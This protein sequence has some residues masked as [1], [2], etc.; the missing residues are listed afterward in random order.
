MTD[1]LI[2]RLD[3][4]AESDDTPTV[5]YLRRL[6]RVAADA[7][8]DEAA[9]ITDLAG[10]V[11]RLLVQLD[12]RDAA[13]VWLLWERAAWQGDNLHGIY[14]SQQTAETARTNLAKRGVRRSYDFFIEEQP[15]HDTP[16]TNPQP[17]WH[18]N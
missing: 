17:T 9:E 14:L 7:L 6:C 1:H 13:R 10:T 3:D 8:A 2:A 11:A 4:A 12:A 5:D 16:A 18:G 15:V